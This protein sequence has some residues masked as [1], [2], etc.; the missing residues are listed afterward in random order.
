MNITQPATSF[1]RAAE[2]PYRLVTLLKNTTYDR[3]WRHPRRLQWP[4]LSVGNLSTGGTGKTPFVLLLAQ[5]L[6]AEGWEADVLTRGYGRRSPLVARVMP[7]TDDPDPAATFG[8]EPLLLAHRGLPVFVG[9]DRWQAGCCA[10]Q[11]GD[12]QR[13]H[14]LDDGFQHRRLARAL[15]IVLLQRRDFSDH[16]LPIGRLREPLSSLYRSDICVLTVED[17]NLRPQAMRWM[18]TDDPRRVWLIERQTTVPPELHGEPCLAF[19]GIGSP[20][21]FFAGI[22]RAG[23]TP[24]TTLRWPDHHRYTSADIRRLQAA[25]RRHHAAAFLT[26]E[27]DSWRLTPAQRSALKNI[28][29]LYVAPLT[30]SLLDPSAA[31]D[32]LRLRLQNQR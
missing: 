11:T 28:A 16:L 20:G 18:H 9:A 32:Y 23:A 21:Q 24:V 15:D 4:V 3:G 30:I 31:L 2:L 1:L 7:R 12:R 22:E 17:A 5:L 8:D 10:E 6:A 19:C 26:T 27:K 13:I 29:P 25:A 14:L